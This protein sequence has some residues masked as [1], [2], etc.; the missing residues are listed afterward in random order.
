MSRHDPADVVLI[1]PRALAANSPPEQAV[2]AVMVKEEAEWQSAFPVD[3][4]LHRERERLRND[5]E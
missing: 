3:R 5:T 1:G 2:A 4:S